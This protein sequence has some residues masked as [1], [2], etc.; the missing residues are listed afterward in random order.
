MSNL[1]HRI[2]QT[3]T[4]AFAAMENHIHK[5]LNKIRPAFGLWRGA[6]SGT[7][8]AKVRKDVESGLSGL[9]QIQPQDGTADAAENTLQSQSAGSLEADHEEPVDLLPESTSPDDVH[10]EQEELPQPQFTEGP[11]RF[12]LAKDGSKGLRSAACGRGIPRQSY[13]VLFQAEPGHSRC[14]RRTTI[15]TRRWICQDH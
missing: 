3:T 13:D 1:Y 12:V 6:Y 14:S 11:P 5:F 4:F 2:V 7:L 9:I 10:V 8:S 15:A